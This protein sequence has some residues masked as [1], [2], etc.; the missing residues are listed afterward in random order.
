MGTLFY[1]SA[2]MF[3]H[4]IL[5]IKEKTNVAG[6]GAISHNQGVFFRVW[7][8]HAE[9]VSVIGDFNDWKVG[10]DM[11]VAEGNGHWGINVDNAKVGDEYKFHLNTPFGELHRNDPYA[12]QM[13]HSNGNGII[14][15]HS[16]FDW[17]GYDEFEMPAWNQLVIYELHIGT[18]NVKEGQEVGDFYS[19]IEKLQY[20]KDLGINAVEVMPAAEFPGA[21]SWGYNP[22][23][24]FAIET[25]Y[26]GPDGFK[27]FIKEA[28]KL[29]IAVIFDVV[30]NHFGPS[31]LDMWQFDGW[32]ENDGG[33]IY[34]YNDWRRET[35]W[36]DSRPDY[37]R[38]E[39]RDYIRNNALMWLEEYKADGLRMDMVPY[40]RNVKAD[41]NPGNDIPEGSSLIAEINTEIRNKFPQKITIAE[42]MHS[43]DSITLES[44]AGGLNYGSQWDA[45]FVHPVR[46]ALIQ[47]DDEHR[48]MASVAT[49]ILHRY[50]HDSFERIIYTESHDEVANGQARIAEEIA[51]D[52]VDNY[53]SKKRATLGVGLVMTSPGIPM[54]FQGQPILEDKWF[55]DTDPL[56][57]TRAEKFEGIV[58]MHR[59][60]IHLRRNLTGQTSG[61]TGQHIEMLRCDEEKKII[62]FRRWANGGCGDEVLVVLNFSN[63]AYTDFKFGIN[64][65]CNY[66]LIFNSDATL[67]DNEFSGIDACINEIHE[68][69]WD[70]QPFHTEITIPPY[71]TL[72]FATS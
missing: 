37:G 4:N 56:D 8:P 12:L 17:E 3:K 59:D 49:A 27:N 5:M 13:N 24:P 33:G 7:A 30:Y 2:R 44:G 19:A 36:G 15:D 41:G 62:I 31:D 72:I 60:L 14:Y 58:A 68:G 32:S 48:N 23:Q 69:E 39:V 9:Q 54:L 65:N 57:W 45:E 22:A 38:Q 63:H 70:N 34:F 43:L 11:L 29:G 47:Q 20:L 40:I 67:Y 64:N 10:K 6:M 26:G 61:L 46:E 50:N 35:P 18:F 42:D 25:D 51:A 1:L 55:S 21:R 71:T 66:Q 16:K 53:Y 28:H 52:D